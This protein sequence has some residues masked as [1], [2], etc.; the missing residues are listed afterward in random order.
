MID[1]ADSS[2]EEVVNIKNDWRQ[3]ND[4][5]TFYLYNDFIVNIY[6]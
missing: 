1:Q 2:P 4:K 5:N 6:I 3:V